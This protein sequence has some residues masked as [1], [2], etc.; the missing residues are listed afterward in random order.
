MKSCFKISIIIFSLETLE[1]LWGLMLECPLV[2]AVRRYIDRRCDKIVQLYQESNCNG[3]SVITTTLVN[4]FNYSWRPKSVSC[5]GYSHIYKKCGSWK[6]TDSGD[7]SWNYCEGV[8]YG[9][10]KVFPIGDRDRYL[11]KY[12]DVSSS[13]SIKLKISAFGSW[14]WLSIILGKK[15]KHMLY[16]NQNPMV[17][18]QIF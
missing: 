17:I 16:A 13:E 3:N 18:R 9:R 14:S 1:M 10:L 5:R 4:G 6:K 7:H 2:A 11:F 12:T 15:L 8:D